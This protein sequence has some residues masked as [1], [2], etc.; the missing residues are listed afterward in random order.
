[1]EKEREDGKEGAK[2]KEGRDEKDLRGGSER[3]KKEEKERRGGQMTRKEGTAE[4]GGEVDRKTGEAESNEVPCAEFFLGGR[5]SYQGTT[6][7][8]PG[9]LIEP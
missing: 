7:F 2:R 9:A 5:N 6:W 4:R 1:M 3:R 8:G